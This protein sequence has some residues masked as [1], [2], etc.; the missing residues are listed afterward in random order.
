M[1]EALSQIQPGRQVRYCVCCPTLPYAV[2]CEVSAHLRQ[3]TGVDA[4]LLPQTSQ[5]FDYT[6]SQVGGLWIEY[7]Q[8]ADA[9]SRHQVEQILNYYGDRYGRWLVMDS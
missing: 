2:Y 6:Q 7:S 1:N 8:T 5:Q 4:G 9:S 3:V